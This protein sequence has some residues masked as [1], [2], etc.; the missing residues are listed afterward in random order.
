MAYIRIYIVLRAL[1]ANDTDLM[2]LTF[3]LLNPQACYAGFRDTEG[4]RNG[5]RE[6]A[7]ERDRE[8]ERESEKIGRAHV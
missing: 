6:S 3:K 7:R 1:N 8:I 2:S 4:K 5:R